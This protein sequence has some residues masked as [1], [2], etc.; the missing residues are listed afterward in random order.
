MRDIQRIDRILELLGEAWKKNPDCRFGQLLINLGMVSDK[1]L[2]WYAED[3][4]IEKALRK[5]LKKK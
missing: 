4:D 2:V 3:R 1:D 5:Y